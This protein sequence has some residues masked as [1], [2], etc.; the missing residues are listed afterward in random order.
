MRT[1]NFRKGRYIL[2]KNISYPEC[3]YCKSTQYEIIDGPKLGKSKYG[4]DIYV[5]ELQCKECEKRYRWETPLRW[6]LG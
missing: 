2:L 5:Y 1:I 4:M 3:L 6:I